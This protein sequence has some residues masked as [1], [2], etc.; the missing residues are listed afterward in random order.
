LF[1]QILPR[2]SVQIVKDDISCSSALGN[3]T[4]PRL[5]VSALVRA[6]EPIER[7]ASALDHVADALC[8]CIQRER[9]G[10]HLH[11]RRQQIVADCGVVRVEADRA[12]LEP[13]VMPI[14]NR[15]STLA[16]WITSLTP[17]SGRW[18]V[19]LPPES[20]RTRGAH[21]RRPPAA[22]CA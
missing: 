20:R 2:M 3:I 17:S 15:I 13:T 6:K 7:C 9:F 19:K 21:C 18:S 22:T 11:A 8:Q 1:R 14:G 16:G 5:A 4:A 10:D 12:K